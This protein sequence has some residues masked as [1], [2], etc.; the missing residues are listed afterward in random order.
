MTTE[1]NVESLRDLAIEAATLKLLAERVAVARKDAQARTQRALDAAAARDGVERITATLPGGETV[2]TIS[3]RKGET[4]PVVVDED[5]FARWVR[6]TFPD[7]QWTETAIVRRVKAW[8][9][10]ELLAEMAA[11]GAARV[12]VAEQV[13]EQTGEVIADAVVHDVPGVA[14]RPTRARTH[15]VTWRRGGKDATAEAWRTGALDG[16]LAALTA[17][18]GDAA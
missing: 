13:D 17:R 16:Q 1:Q 10:A 12:V 14:I 7:E 4:G 2:A 11:A 9:A 8:K 5:T 18:E 6:A 3:L 15:A